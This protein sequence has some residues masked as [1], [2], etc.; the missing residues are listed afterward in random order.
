M[1]TPL[2]NSACVGRTLGWVLGGSALI[3]STRSVRP[4]FLLFVVSKRFKIKTSK[5]A[6]SYHWPGWNGVV[7]WCLIVRVMDTFFASR[8]RLNLEFD[9]S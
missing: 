5:L 4:K 9:F 6:A 3:F 2:A 1:P 7:M 8:P